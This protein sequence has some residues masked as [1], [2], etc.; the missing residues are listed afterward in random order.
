VDL[1]RPLSVPGRAGDGGIH[2]GD[3]LLDWSTATRGDAGTLDA[4]YAKCAFHGVP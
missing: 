3:S 4:I 2:G 1:G